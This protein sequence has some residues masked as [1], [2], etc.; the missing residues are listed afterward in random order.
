MADEPAGDGPQDGPTII[1]YDVQKDCR[2]KLTKDGTN[3]ILSFECRHPDMAENF[4]NWISRQIDYGCI[5]IHTPALHGGWD[6]EKI[7]AMEERRLSGRRL[8]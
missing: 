5:H 8:S 6:E 7:A 1:G 3:V 2:V 4:A